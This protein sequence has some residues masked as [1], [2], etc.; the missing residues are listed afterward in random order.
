[1][2]GVTLAKVNCPNPD[3]GIA[4]SGSI[5]GPAFHRSVQRSRLREAALCLYPDSKYAKEHGG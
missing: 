3:K 2:K 4:F 5:D 1:V